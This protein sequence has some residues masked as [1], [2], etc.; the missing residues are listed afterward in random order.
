MYLIVSNFFP[1]KKFCIDS[2][3]T[4]DYSQSHTFHFSIYL[5][6]NCNPRNAVWELI[7]IHAVQCDNLQL[8]QEKCLKAI[9]L[10]VNLRMIRKRCIEELYDWCALNGYPKCLQS[11]IIKDSEQLRAPNECNYNFTSKIE[12]KISAP[13]L[14]SKDRL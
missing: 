12:R 5:K 1:R 2:T 6:S 10:A 9:I 13:V 14:F 4:F 3:S 8:N 7:V 11:R